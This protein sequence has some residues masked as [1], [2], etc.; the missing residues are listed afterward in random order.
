MS[1]SNISTPLCPVKTFVETLHHSEVFAQNPALSN[2]SRNTASD[3]KRSAKFALV[4]VSNYIL[5]LSNCSGQD[6][7]P[8]KLFTE[9]ATF[10]KS[11]QMSLHFRESCENSLHFRESC[12]NSLQ[13]SHPAIWYARHI[14]GYGPANLGK[15]Y[16]ETGHRVKHAHCTKVMHTPGKTCTLHANHAHRRD[17]IRTASTRCAPQA[18]H[19]HRKHKMRTAS[20]ASAPQA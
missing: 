10:F 11:C 7:F 1:V 6:T 2:C 12:E 9:I 8:V 15:V 19:P 4:K 17:T 5:G 14:H 18:Q 20:T 16:G 13:F 3:S